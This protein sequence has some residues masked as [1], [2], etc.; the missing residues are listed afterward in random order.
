MVYLKKLKEEI[1]RFKKLNGIKHN[2][3]LAKM[4]GISPTHLSGILNQKTYI[5][6][7]WKSR[8]SSVLG[9]PQNELFDGF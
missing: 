4:F 2:C 8:I 5:F 9:V 7:T 6:P 3:D 1:E